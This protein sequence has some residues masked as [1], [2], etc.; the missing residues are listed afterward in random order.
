MNDPFPCNTYQ[1]SV[2]CVVYSKYIVKRL[3]RSFLQ[4]QMIKITLNIEIYLR[5]LGTFDLF[6]G[7][8]L[9]FRKRISYLDKEYKK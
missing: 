5:N 4:K 7:R 3:W 6:T 1:C 2:A 8:D 9:P